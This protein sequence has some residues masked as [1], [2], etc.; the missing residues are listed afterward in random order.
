MGYKDLPRQSA[1]NERHLALG[2]KLDADWNGMPIPQTYATDPYEETTLVRSRAGLFDVTGLRIVDVSGPDALAMLDAMLTSDISKLKPGESAI[3]NIVDD[4]G[5]LIDDV[6]VYCDGPQAYRIS[7]GGG[8]LEGALPLFTQGRDVSVA[9]DDDVHILS[10]Q[11]PLALDIL[12]PHTPLDLA[13]LKYF[14]HARTTL[15][16]FDVS[17]ARG[18]YSAERGY[19]VFCKAADAVAIWDAILEAG[20]PFGICAASWACLDIVRVEGALLFFPFDMPRP[21]TTPWEVGA[22]WTVDLGKPD[23]RGKAALERRRNEVRFRQVGLEIL[24]DAAVPPGATI[25]H[26]GRE[27]GTVNSTTYSRHLM[28]S[29]GLAHLPPELAALGTAVEIRSDKGTLAANVVRTPFYD[30]M[31]LRTHPLDER[32]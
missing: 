19:E 17:L 18:G 31:R 20:K 25:L 14:R 27:V 30:P 3:S 29:L 21:D 16:G 2:S 13:G 9:K 11:G 12:K 4:E 28:K 32:A 1:L 26:E 10:L 23:F 24:D 22:D 15:F 6:L 8:D 5:S 7:H